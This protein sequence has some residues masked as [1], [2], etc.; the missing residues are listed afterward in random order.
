V[1]RVEAEGPLP[2]R[3]ARDLE[4]ALIEEFD[5]PHNK[6]YTPRGRHGAPYSTYP[7]GKA[8]HAAELAEWRAEWDAMTPDEQQAYMES[9]TPV[10]GYRRKAS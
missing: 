5:P 6:Q 3:D 8:Q 9:I 1:A 10:R 4:R 2:L 7:G